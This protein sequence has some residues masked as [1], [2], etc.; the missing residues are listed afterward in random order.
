MLTPA[1][2]LLATLRPL[3]LTALCGVLLLLPLALHLQ[4]PLRHPHLTLLGTGDS[5]SLLLEGAH[6]G[7]VLVGGGATQSE[8]PASLARHL[9]PWDR[10]IDLLIVA[11]RRDLPGATELVRRGVARSVATVGLTAQREAAASLAA[12]EAACAERNVPLR[13]IEAGE[14][15]TIGRDPPIT[16]TIQPPASPDTS[17]TLHLEAGPFTAPVLLGATADDTRPIGA[18]LLRTNQETFALAAAA[19]ARLL[20]APALPTDLALTDPTDRY[21]LHLRPGDRATLIVDT[22]TLRLRGAP[23]IPLDAVTP[24]R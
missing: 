22:H 14:Q 1:G 21:L 16:L 4:R 11:D 6:G 12:L 9:R 7:R 8:L 15:L 24:Q 3:A 5:L 18:I 13:R 19:D 23:L 17:P 2:R 10:Q 20:A